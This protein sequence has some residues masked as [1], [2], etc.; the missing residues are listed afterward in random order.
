MKE[1]QGKRELKKILYSKIFVA[2]LLLVVGLMSYRIWGIGQ[3]GR[4]VTAERRAMLAQV[5]ELLERKRALENDL[6]MLKTTRGV[7]EAIRQRFSVVKVGEGVVVV[8]ASTTTAPST[9]TTK[10][11]WQEFKS[12]LK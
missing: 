3:Q 12:W 6:T 1:F 10:F 4:V 8:V 9:T 7:E 5:T 2:L 11:W